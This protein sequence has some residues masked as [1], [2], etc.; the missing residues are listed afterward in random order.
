MTERDSLGFVNDQIGSPTDSLGLA[1]VLWDLAGHSLRGQNS[2]PEGIGPVIYRWSDTGAT[3]WY[4]FA[5]E[6]QRQAS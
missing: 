1:K 4:G 2:Q 5:M 3:S 6:I